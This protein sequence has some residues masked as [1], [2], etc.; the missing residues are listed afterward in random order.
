MHNLHLYEQKVAV[1]DYNYY[2]NSAYRLL[3]VQSKLKVEEIVMVLRLG[4]WHNVKN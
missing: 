1:F 4:V 2:I 3:D